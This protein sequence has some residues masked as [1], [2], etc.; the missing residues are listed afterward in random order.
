TLLQIEPA[1]LGPGDESIPQF[2]DAADP[3]GPDVAHVGNSLRPKLL[4]SNVHRSLL[5]SV[6]L[7][8]SIGRPTRPCVARVAKLFAELAVQPA[9]LGPALGAIAAP[10]GGAHTEVAFEGA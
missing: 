6:P 10:L 1:G 3:V 8:R 9:P 5:G 4:Y 7:G 2:R